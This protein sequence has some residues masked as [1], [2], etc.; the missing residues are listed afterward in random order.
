MGGAT[1][2]PKNCEKQPNYAH[3]SSPKTEQ[4]EPRKKERIFEI[5]R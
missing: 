2:S 1:F 3:F 4:Q 5:P